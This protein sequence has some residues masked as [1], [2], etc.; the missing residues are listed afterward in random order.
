MMNY[1]KPYEKIREKEKGGEG[2]T[3]LSCLSSVYK[4]SIPTYKLIKNKILRKL[5]KNPGWYPKIDIPIKTT[6]NL[7]KVPNPGVN[8]R[9]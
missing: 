7:N 4:A 9:S 5:L 3:F 6:H 2:G 8:K 1:E